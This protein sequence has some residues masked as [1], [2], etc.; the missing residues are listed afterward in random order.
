MFRKYMAPRRSS[1]KKKLQHVKSEIHNQYKIICTGE[2]IADIVLNAGQAEDLCVRSQLGAPEQE[3]CDQVNTDVRND[4]L[5]MV[6]I[7]EEDEEVRTEEDVQLEEIC[8]DPS[9]SGINIG[10]SNIEQV[11]DVCLRNRLQSS[12][13]DVSE[14]D[15]TNEA[16]S[17]NTEKQYQPTPYFSEDDNS[18]PQI[19]RETESCSL[20]EPMLYESGVSASVS[21]Q[22]E[23]TINAPS[24][25][26]HEGSSEATCGPKRLNSSDIN[27][28]KRVHKKAAFY[29]PQPSHIDEKLPKNKK[30][31]TFNSDFQVAPNRTHT[32]NKSYACPVSDKCFTK[33]TKL[34]EHL[35]NHSRKY[36]CPEC[37]KGYSQRWYLVT[38]HRIHTGEK[39]FVCP[40][41]NKRFTQRSNLYTH[42]KTHTGEKPF[43]CP[44]CHMCFTTRSYLNIHQRTHTGT[45]N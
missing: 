19:S 40:V 20:T 33:K 2:G 34:N 13:M 5:D 30:S 17:K 41:C 6:M 25:T 4:N 35:G 45:K 10:A 42:Q 12:D 3:I 27:C 29:V 28:A 15:V 38:H 11:E 14:D 7:C 43:M 9:S 32:E 37:G 36:V 1:M 16:T 18:Q 31:Y 8:S 26:F 23:Q 24:D 44:E 39:P 22:W 21:H